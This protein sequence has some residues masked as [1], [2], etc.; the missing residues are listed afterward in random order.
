M[1]RNVG[2][3]L[4]HL[5]GLAIA[6]ENRVIAGLQ[7][8]LAPAATTAR[9][10]TGIVFAAPQ[11]VPEQRVGWALCKSRI[12]KHA[13]ML[14]F[15]FVQA[16]AQRGQEIVVAVQND[17]LH[18]ELDHPLRLVDGRLQTPQVGQFKNI[19][20]GL[21]PGLQPLLHGLR[22]QRAPKYILEKTHDDGTS[23]SLSGLNR[24]GLAIQDHEN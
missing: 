13:V 19:D 1:R 2:R 12:D 22:L 5:E 9:V 23:W 14:A 3:V 24:H 17:A 11:L 15:D 16:I 4:D 20:R 10:L 7:P 18:I 21:R 6:I 8:D